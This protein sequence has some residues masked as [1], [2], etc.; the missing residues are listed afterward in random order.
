MVTLINM[1][2]DYV[3]KTVTLSMCHLY[4]HTNMQEN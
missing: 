1:D 2:E 3:S 4:H